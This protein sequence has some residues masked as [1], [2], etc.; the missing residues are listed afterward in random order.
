M[1]AS[2]DASSSASSHNT[3]YFPITGGEALS[4][5][6]TSFLCESLDAGSCPEL[7]GNSSDTF[8]LKNLS[9][10]KCHTLPMVTKYLYK[11]A[12]SHLSFSSP[13]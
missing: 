6:S 2:S 3:K 11:V 9:R 13:P 4:E 8:P 1:I 10:S 7:L 12:R 5:L